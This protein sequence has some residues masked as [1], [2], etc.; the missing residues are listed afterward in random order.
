MG[1]YVLIAINFVNACSCY[2][3][4]TTE[5][6]YPPLN[7]NTKDNKIK[8]AAKTRK[9]RQ[10][11][12]LVWISLAD[13]FSQHFPS[14]TRVFAISAINQIFVIIFHYGYYHHHLPN[15][16]LQ[17]KKFAGLGWWSSER[18]KE[19]K[20]ASYRLGANRDQWSLWQTP[21]QLA[22]ILAL[23]Q[24]NHLISIKEIFWNSQ[25]WSKIFFCQ[26]GQKMV[27]FVQGAH[28]RCC[29]FCTL[30]FMGVV[31]GI[32]GSPYLWYFESNFWCYS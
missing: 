2:V 32:M 4:V 13:F 5:A 9:G 25:V 17:K 8:N 31:Q 22:Q 24:I 29:C 12:K 30:W 7:A 19:R 3:C 26:G 27:I 23:E 1:L 20:V 10:N 28:W 15:I 6:E 18:K 21:H 16:C 11:L 14:C